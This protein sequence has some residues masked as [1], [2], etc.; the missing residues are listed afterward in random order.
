MPDQFVLIKIDGMHC[1]RCQKAIQKALQSTAGVFEAE[2][3]F[4]TK[5]ASVLYDPTQVNVRQLVEAVGEAGYRTT[6]F[7]QGQAEVSQG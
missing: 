1:H 3:D 2:V 5:Q 7:M 4:P 6:G